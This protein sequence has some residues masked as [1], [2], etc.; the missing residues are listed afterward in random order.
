[1]KKILI[2]LFLLL[3]V[4][5]ANAQINLIQT[6]NDNLYY[7][8]G[9]ATFSYLGDKL[10]AINNVS[11]SERC[12][13]IFIY[14]QDLSV[15]KKL[16]VT[17]VTHTPFSEFNI[18]KDL[19]GA[20]GIWLSDG[21]FNNDSLIEFSIRSYN[22]DR[23]TYTYSI[24]NEQE[25]IFT[26]E[27]SYYT[28]FPKIYSLDN[29]FY[30][31][32]RIDDNTLNYYSLPGSLPCNNCN[33]LSGLSE[34]KTIRTVELNAFPNP[35]TNTLQIQYKLSGNQSNSK[36]SVTNIL[37]KEISSFS[38]DNPAGNISLDAAHLS[39]G[40]YII[41]LYENSSIISKK[42]IKID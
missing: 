7:N 1:M 36:I 42:L 24:M 26:I 5:S 13:T 23:N 33:V 38:L 19:Q 22:P 27:Q 32:I 9:K 11:L 30:L 39:K 21:L 40:T 12:D 37:G 41:S 3:V 6:Q 31:V 10:Y 8:L 35:F 29:S 14:N 16:F 15:Y 2:S 34:D 18:I 20:T 4:S 28:E 25:V 17:D